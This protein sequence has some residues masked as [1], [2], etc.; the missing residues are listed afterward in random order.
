MAVRI[1]RVIRPM[2][3]CAKVGIV[4]DEEEEQGA[5]D[6]NELELRQRYRRGGARPVV[7]QRDLAKY[8][9]RPH[10]LD[11]A[12]PFA[13][14]DLPGPDDIGAIAIFV[15]AIDR[16]PGVEMEDLSLGGG[17]GIGVE[18]RVGHGGWFPVARVHAAE[19]KRGMLPSPA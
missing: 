8:L 1:R 13:D 14:L 7:D 9:A 4:A 5:A 16:G 18:S 3:A 2:T 6:R 19:M 11:G 15:M 10:G 12:T 17:N